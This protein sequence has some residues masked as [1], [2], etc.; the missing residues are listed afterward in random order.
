[1]TVTAS[2]GTVFTSLSLATSTIC[3]LLV[4]ISD[5]LPTPADHWPLAGVVIRASDMAGGW[6]AASHFI[7]APPR[8]VCWSISASDMALAPELTLLRS[9]TRMW[10]KSLALIMPA[11]VAEAASHS[12]AEGTFCSAAGTDISPGKIKHWCPP[13]AARLRRAAGLKTRSLAQQGPP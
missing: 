8:S 2:Q 1:M 9:C 7:H 12:G 11:T 13:T 10:M 5:R 3:S 4:H 6:N